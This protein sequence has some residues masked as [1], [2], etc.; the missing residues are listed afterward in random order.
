MFKKGFR[1]KIAEKSQE[2]LMEELSKNAS[3]GKIIE[4]MN[5]ICKNN[6]VIAE[7]LKEVMDRM[8]DITKGICT[9]YQNQEVISKKQ[10]IELP[11]PLTNMRV[12]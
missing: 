7:R 12:E 2:K 11:E 1:D 3:I 4:L 10:N 9:L 5:T 6:D 8:D